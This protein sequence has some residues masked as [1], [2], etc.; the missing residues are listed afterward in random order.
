MATS[1]GTLRRCDQKVG[2]WLARWNGLSKKRPAAP[3]GVADGLQRA[4]DGLRAVISKAPK[5]GPVAAPSAAEGRREAPAGK[6]D[7]KRRKPRLDEKH[8]RVHDG[9]RWH[10]VTAGGLLMLSYLFKAEG[11]WVAGKDI[12]GA[13]RRPDKLLKAMPPAVQELVESHPVNGYRIPALLPE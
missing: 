6:R 12:H 5:D 4:A 2:A 7:E 3:R 13:S 1:L 8:G 10:D 11:G 9:G